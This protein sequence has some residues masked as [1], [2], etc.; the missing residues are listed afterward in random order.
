L[1]SNIIV[2]VS[3]GTSVPGIAE[4]S[5]GTGDADGTVSASVEFRG[6]TDMIIH[7]G[8]LLGKASLSTFSCGIY[9]DF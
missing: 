1:F 7:K 3:S 8:K 5:D 4:S 6:K 2:S 9:S